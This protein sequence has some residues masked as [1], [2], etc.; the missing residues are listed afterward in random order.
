MKK[1]PFCAEE[2]QD[3]AIKC[4]H[5]GSMLDG[6][7]AP[8]EIRGVDPFA[9][10]HTNITGKKKGDLSF[11]GYLGLGLG[12]MLIAMSCV[13]LVSG[14]RSGGSEADAE[15]IFFV[16]LVGWGLALASYFWARR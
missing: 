2:I 6:T 5:C 11:V 10:Y 14:T 9:A 16:L 7:A 4:R 15:G 3:Q 1:C 8:V 13:M 12:V